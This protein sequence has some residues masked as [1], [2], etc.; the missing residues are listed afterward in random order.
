M[1]EIVQLTEANESALQDINELIRQLS[2][3]LPECSK[4]LLDQ[5][6]HDQNIELWVAQDAGRIVGMAT[7]AIVLIPE[8]PRGQLEDIVVHEKYRGRGLGEQISQ[9]LIERAR[10]RDVQVVT[11]SS[12][13]D[14]VAANKLYQKLGFE[15]RE[16]NFY[17]LEL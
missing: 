10:A 4:E 14:R 2:P 7:L 9:Q 17:R 15:M 12:R 11:L 6:V 5:I 1:V 3:R 8:G 13:A 16:T